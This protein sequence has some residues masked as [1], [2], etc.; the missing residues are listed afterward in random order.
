MPT[1]SDA[2]ATGSARYGVLFVCT[3]NICRSPSAE[4]VFR[5]H[6]RD[7]GLAGQVL[8]ESA[9]THGYHQGEGADRRSVAAAQKRGYDLAAHRARRLERP[10]FF[11]FELLLALDKGHYATMARMVR[12]SDGHKLRMLMDFA[13]RHPGVTEVPDPYYGGPEGFERVLDMLEDA[14]EGL[15]ETVRAALAARTGD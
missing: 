7:A 3:G 11:R 2:P 15:L 6:V 13:R 1:M 5:K 12:P 14:A 10:D 9:G 4:G 8:I